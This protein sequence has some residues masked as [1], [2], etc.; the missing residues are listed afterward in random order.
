MGWIVDEAVWLIGPA[1]VDIF[2]DGQPSERFEA[3]G[4]VVGVHEGVEVLTKLVM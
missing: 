3:L 4:E 1:F 2:E